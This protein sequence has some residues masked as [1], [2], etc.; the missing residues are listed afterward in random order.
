MRSFSLLADFYRE[1]RAYFLYGNHDM[2]KK[3]SRFAARQ[4]QTGYCCRFL[5]EEP[6]FPGVV[7]YPGII[8]KDSAG[9]R[10]ICLTHGHQADPLNST[11]WKLSRFLV[12]FLWGNLERL[13]IPD[14]TS[15]AKNHTRKKK[16]EEKL[17]R[18]AAARDVILITG[19]TH[20]PLAGQTGAH[21]LNTGSCVSP[22][23]I[24]AIEIRSRTLTL[25]K[26]SLDVRQDQSL[27]V[28]REALGE[29]LTLNRF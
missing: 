26:W 16:S 10:N 1:K 3:S 21:Y 24:T 7:Y 11:F 6:L 13:G 8:L 23:G 9:S 2:V 14:P 22:A 20:H 17:A 18:W 12:R 27:C 28:S 5:T 4:L 15:A 29:A 19:H 25:V